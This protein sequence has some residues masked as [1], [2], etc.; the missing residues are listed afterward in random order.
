M[1]GERC[2][3]RDDE[4][5]KGR[6]KVIRSIIQIEKVYE[7]TLWKI[8]I[9]TYSKLNGKITIEVNLKE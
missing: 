8:N 5:K 6:I 9:L 1:K 7:H 2:R 3:M 4:K